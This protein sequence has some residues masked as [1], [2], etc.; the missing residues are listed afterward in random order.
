MPNEFYLFPVWVGSLKVQII[1]TLLRCPAEG[2][3][4]NF[5]NNTLLKMHIKHYHRELRKMLGATP[6]VLD[7]AAARTK[8]TA[9]ELARPDSKVLKVKINRPPKRD[10]PKQESEFIEPL[11]TPTK[12]ETLPKI[13]RSQD[14]PKL[15]NALVNKPVKRPKVLL[16]MRRLESELHPEF[17]EDDDFDIPTQVIPPS[18]I[19]DFEAAISTHTVTKPIEHKK[20]GDKKKSFASFAKNISEDEEWFAMNSDELE[21][22]SSFPRSGTPD[23]AKIIDPKTGFMLSSD[24][25]DDSMD[26]SCY[27][28]TES[29]YNLITHLNSLYWET[30]CLIDFYIMGVVLIIPMLGM[31]VEDSSGVR[32]VR[33]EALLSAPGGIP[34]GR[35]LK[36]YFSHNV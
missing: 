20:K 29:K 10:E 31:R 14:S 15:R 19:L 13:P 21:T 1:D 18:D 6:K 36:M 8:P 27:T 5:R 3:F 2:C 12:N 26:P 11:H 9:T 28:F 7:L 16:P 35:I 23:D 17:M 22:R 30:S 4:K 33:Q 24:T 25:M 34:E 32:I